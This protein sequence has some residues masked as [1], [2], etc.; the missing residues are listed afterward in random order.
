MTKKQ[1]LE[2]ESS[3]KQAELHD[4]KETLV[5]EKENIESEADS[6]LIDEIKPSTWAEPDSDFD[7]DQDNVGFGSNY[8]EDER[9]KLEEQYEGTLNSIN[10]GE[11]VPGT[12]VSINN[13]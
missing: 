8:N 10:R 1:E 2:K 9:V 12:V 3:A 6:N 7:W 5:R 13:K 4:A 11:I